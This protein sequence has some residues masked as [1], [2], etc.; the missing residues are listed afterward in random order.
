MGRQVFV[1]T[2]YDKLI[3]ISEDTD[4]FVSLTET[5]RPNPSFVLVYNNPVLK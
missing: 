4:T 3:T 5:A 2:L 1:F